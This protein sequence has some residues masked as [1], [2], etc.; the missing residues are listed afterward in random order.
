MRVAEGYRIR[1]VG[2]QCPT[3]ASL[4]SAGELDEDSVRR[5]PW[6]SPY[7][8]HC[9][10]GRTR[11]LSNGPDERAGDEDDISAP[12]CGMGEGPGQAQRGE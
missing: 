6:G 12:G 10:E 4:L 2:A 7:Q 11:V 3:V 1:H 8:I 5:D 9:E